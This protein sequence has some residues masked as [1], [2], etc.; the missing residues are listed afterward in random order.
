MNMEKGVV[1]K[2]MA[3]HDAGRFY[4]VVKAEKDVAFIADGKRRKVEKPKRKNVKHLAC[5][6][7]KLNEEEIHTDKQIRKNLWPYNYGGSRY[8]LDY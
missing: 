3:G 8:E 4:V 1:V 2:S 6:K 5:T 7:C